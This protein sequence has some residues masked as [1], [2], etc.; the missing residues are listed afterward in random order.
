MAEHLATTDQSS[1]GSNW[2]AGDIMYKD[3]N[4]DG[5]I[6]SGNYTINDHGD[7]KLIGNSTPRYFFGLNLDAS[8]K[9]FD[10]RMF[11]QGVMKR[12][13]MLNDNPFMF[14]FASNG[15]W[16]ASGIEGVED[17]FRNEDSW[18]VAN[19]YQEANLNAY[20]PR[21]NGGGKNLQSQTRYLLDA[22]YM[23]LKN[24]QIGYTLPQKLVSSWGIQ[25]LRF[26]VSVD[27]L[28]TITSLPKQFDPELLG[29]Q[30]NNGY[31]LSRTWSFGLNITL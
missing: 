20:L 2:A 5:R 8:W 31:P 24:M 23:R 14:G 21:V 18:S 28:A 1:L 10:V 17:Y 27:N 30:N 29:I 7:L 9:G 15:N 25:N 16:W 26:Y 6:S 4:G 12:D 13:Y 22:S 19:G 3:L 11:F